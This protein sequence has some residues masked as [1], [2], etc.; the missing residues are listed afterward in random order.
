MLGV[1]ASVKP[2]L[3]FNKDPGNSD[4]VASMMMWVSA[5]EDTE[6]CGTY[7]R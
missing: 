3:V 7:M 4:R 1:S 5:V 6:G 2:S